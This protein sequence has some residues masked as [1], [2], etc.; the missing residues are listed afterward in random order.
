MGVFFKFL[1]KENC[2]FLRKDSIRQCGVLLDGEGV[3]TLLAPNSH[4]AQRH[5]HNLTKMLTGIWGCGLAT[6]EVNRGGEGKSKPH[7]K[8]ES[9]TEECQVNFCG[10]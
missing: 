6:R 7:V 9:L 3:N 2:F 4:L 5:G 10:K 8:R 1:E